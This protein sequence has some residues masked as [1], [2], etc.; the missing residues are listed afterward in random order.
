MLLS[1]YDFDSSGEW[2]DQ[3]LT[4][5]LNDFPWIQYLTK[6]QIK[7]GSDVSCPMVIGVKSSDFRGINDE[8]CQNRQ[9]KK[10]L[11]Q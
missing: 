7:L 10:G 5:L 4:F 8:E 2:S 1:K 9:G 11:M 3:L 6:Y